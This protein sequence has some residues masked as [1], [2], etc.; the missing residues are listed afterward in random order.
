MAIAREAMV[1][2]GDL[3]L[4]VVSEWISNTDEKVVRGVDKGSGS[5][6]TTDMIVR[7]L[8]GAGAAVIPKA[9]PNSGTP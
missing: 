1:E 2:V 6:V 3:E 4:R 7:E 9:M 8:S 5:T